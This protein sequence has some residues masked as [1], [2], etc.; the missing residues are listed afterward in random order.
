MFPTLKI[1]GL[2]AVLAAG[3]VAAALPTDAS[4]PTG[5]AFAERLPQAAPSDA[6]RIA[7]AAPAT[8]AAPRG[9]ALRDLPEDPCAKAVW[10]YVPRDCLAEAGRP[11]RPVARTIA[12][13]QRGVADT[14][15]PARLAAR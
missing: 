15:A 8:Q 14:R 1:M 9:D 7:P 6:A 5:K 2:S 12:I 11:A 10:P 3:L 13:E 4:V